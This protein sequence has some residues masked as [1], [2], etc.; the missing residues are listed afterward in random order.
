MIYPREMKYSTLYISNY[1][2]YF[3]ESKYSFGHYMPTVYINHYTVKCLATHTTHTH[4][5]HTHYTHTHTLHTNTLKH[6]T[7]TYALHPHTS[8]WLITLYNNDVT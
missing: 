6:F 4:Y 7:H 5:T 1:L 8:Q 2:F 3:T